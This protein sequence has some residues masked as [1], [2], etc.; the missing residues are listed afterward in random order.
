MSL[1][2]ILDVESR[3]I[4]S[5]RD[6][7]RPRLYQK[8]PTTGMPHP[9]NESHS[10][11]S[12]E[13]CVTIAFSARYGSR[14]PRVNHTHRRPHLDRLCARRL[15]LRSVAKSCGEV[16]GCSANELLDKR[17]VISRLVVDLGALDG[18]EESPPLVSAHG[19]PRE[20]GAQ[21]FEIQQETSKASV[22]VEE[23]VNRN[24]LQMHNGGAR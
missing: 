15:A 4:R 2:R 7:P 10:R 6:R 19:D 5:H 20:A 16:L 21:Q 9:T 8:A 14:K 3:P 17:G 22:A 12:G 18:C 24:K 13:P 23:R 1:R 11:H